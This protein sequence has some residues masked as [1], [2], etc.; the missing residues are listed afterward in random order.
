MRLPLLFALACLPLAACNNS[1]IEDGSSSSSSTATSS[2]GS[3]SSSTGSGSTGSS[4]STGSTGSSSSSSSSGGTTGSSGGCRFNVANASRATG[5]AFVT[6]DGTRLGPF[7]V[8]ASGTYRFDGCFTDTT[9]V[10]WRLETVLLQPP[11]TTTDVTLAVSSAV[12]PAF[13]G[14]LSTQTFTHA[15]IPFVQQGAG[16]GVLQRFSATGRTVALVANVTAK[17]G[18]QLLFE[19]DMTW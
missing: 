1:G 15:F 7:E 14:A 5:R 13:N 9:G 11:E 3:T 19:Y 17:S 6:L 4:S 10:E 16:G 2:T 12:P 8:Y 18:S